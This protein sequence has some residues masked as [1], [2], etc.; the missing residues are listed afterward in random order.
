MVPLPRLTGADAGAGAW[1]QWQTV[2]IDVSNLSQGQRLPAY[3]ANGKVRAH[4]LPLTR[5]SN[6][7]Q[8]TLYLRDP[9]A[10]LRE[11]VRNPRF[12]GHQDY[13]GMRVYQQDAHGD[14]APVYTEPRTADAFADIQVRSL[15][16]T[17]RL[18]LTACRSN[19]AT[20]RAS[21][22]SPSA[23]TRPSSAAAPAT[24]LCNLSS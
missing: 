2:K 1:T 5:R 11:L 15:A 21:C 4:R 19:S 7:A 20:T 16:Q 8:V 22:P 13:A 9:A 14:Y 6:V 3:I 12:R 18:V 10:V 17:A 23:R 24:T